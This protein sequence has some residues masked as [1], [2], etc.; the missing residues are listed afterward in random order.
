MARRL[1]AL[2]VVI[3]TAI[4]C[5]SSPRGPTEAISLESAP[6][7][8]A[9]LDGNRIHY[10]TEKPHEFNPAVLDSLQKQKLLGG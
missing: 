4:A 2:L 9:T 6:S 3:S 1:S 10:R 8:F 7:R 5:A